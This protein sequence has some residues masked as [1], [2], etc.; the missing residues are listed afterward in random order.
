M[1]ETEYREAYCRYR[2]DLL[3]RNK[4]LEEMIKKKM[5]G[6]YSIEEINQNKTHSHQFNFEKK[7][8][9]SRKELNPTMDS[10][11]QQKIAEEEEESDHSQNEI[12][13]HSILDDRGPFENY[14][15]G[16]THPTNPRLYMT[17]FNVKASGGINPHT[18][19]K[20]KIRPNVLTKYSYQQK[21][22]NPQFF[23]D[24]NEMSSE[25]KKNSDG[26]FLV[27]WPS[28]SHMPPQYTPLDR[29]IR[30]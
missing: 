13:K 10:E 27:C 18:V 12:Y 9:P 11:K 2:S 16:N 3:G 8:A 7:K 5:D 28:H 23:A 25:Q 1:K 4:Q 15:S 30:K 24:Q 6:T 20:S 29:V 26:P 19:M 22:P 17:T 21:Y 14:G